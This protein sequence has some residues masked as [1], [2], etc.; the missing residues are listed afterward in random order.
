MEVISGQSKDLECIS[1][2]TLAQLFSRQPY[3][4][5]TSCLQLMAGVVSQFKKQVHPC[6]PDKK[7][8]AQDDTGRKSE[9]AGL[10]LR[11][12]VQLFG[13]SEESCL[14]GLPLRML[15]LI[16]EIDYVAWT[17]AEGQSSRAELQQ[18][19]RQALPDE[20]PEV[21]ARVLA[22]GDALE[23]LNSLDQVLAEFAKEC[24]TT[25]VS[26][27]FLRNQLTANLNALQALTEGALVPWPLDARQQLAESEQIEESAVPS[28]Q[29]VV[30]DGGANSQTAQATGSVH[31][32]QATVN[33]PRAVE[34]IYNRDQA[35]QQLRLIANFFAR[36]EPQSPV[37]SMIEK[38]IRWGYTPLPDL[39]NELVQGHDG[40]MGRIGELTGMNAEKVHIPGAPARGL[41]APPSEVPQVPSQQAHQPQTP[42]I[43]EKLVQK[44]ADQPAH[45]EP[46][47]KE[48]VEPTVP[49]TPAKP[50]GVPSFLNL[51]EREEKK[52]AVKRPSGPGGIDLASLGI[53]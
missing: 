48:P 13:E 14:L 21:I 42:N 10:Q 53:R 27:S 25:R 46:V 40:L 50:A 23:A 22:L 16:G 34:P 38:A 39:I 32:E 26:S 33:Q 6:V 43:H 28:A 8:R 41:V 17:G 20:Q 37:A 45:P 11:P 29:Q 4:N 5:L 2:L 44:V 35:F 36:T 1:W 18:Q 12:V 52:P 31:P 19:A 30:D 51:P 15:P 9:R 24:R 47:Q 3:K 49:A 7:L